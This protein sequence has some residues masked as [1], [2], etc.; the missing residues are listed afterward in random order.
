MRL[1]SCIVSRVAPR[2][3]ES[4]VLHAFD[5]RMWRD[6]KYVQST[7]HDS[8]SC[9]LWSAFKQSLGG[10]LSGLPC[11]VAKAMS[12]D[13]EVGSRDWRKQQIYLCRLS[14]LCRCRWRCCSCWEMRADWSSSWPPR[15][16]CRCRL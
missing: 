9:A 7:V 11:E 10:F 1:R 3:S 12:P 5:K 2:S 13:Y 16:Q 6:H 14:G 8:R 4:V 15:R